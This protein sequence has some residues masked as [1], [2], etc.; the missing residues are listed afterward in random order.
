MSRWPKTSHHRNT[1]NPT[2][3]GPCVSFV[4]RY[5]PGYIFFGD[6]VENGYIDEHG[7]AVSPPWRGRAL[8]ILIGAEREVVGSVTF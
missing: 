7:Q 2:F 3:H 6:T 8:R 4:D 5:I 1:V